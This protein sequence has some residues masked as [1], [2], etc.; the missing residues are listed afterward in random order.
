VVVSVVFFFF[1]GRLSAQGHMLCR[2][3]LLHRTWHDDIISAVCFVAEPLDV[4]QAAAPAWQQPSEEGKNYATMWLSQQ[5]VFCSRA[6]VNDIQSYVTMTNGNQCMAK[7]AAG[8][9]AWAW[10]QHGGGCQG[11]FLSSVGPTGPQLPTAAE[12]GGPEIL[13]GRSCQ[14]TN[15]D[16][17]G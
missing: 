7:R 2:L 11:G 15:V 13:M 14:L 16:R 5:G 4:L 10:G 8:G 1:F 3:Q 9:G 12:A 6:V 17:Y